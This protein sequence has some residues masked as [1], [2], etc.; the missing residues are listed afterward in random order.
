MIAEAE[1][2]KK[3][4]GVAGLFAKVALEGGEA[5]Y[6]R[7]GETKRVLRDPGNKQVRLREEITSDIKK[8]SDDLM[9]R[10]CKEC[11]CT[12]GVDCSKYPPQ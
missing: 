2:A 5:A 9:R 6:H 8:Y 4:G 7:N 10:I 1:T 11:P 12:A 3:F